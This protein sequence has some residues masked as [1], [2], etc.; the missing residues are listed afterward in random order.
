MA[1]YNPSVHPDGL[2]PD[3]FD[4]PVFTA[5][6]R[7]HQSLSRTGFR[8]VMAGLCL[9]SF[10]VSVWAWRMGFWP[11]AGFFGLDMLGIYLALKV[12]FRRGASFEEV[13]ISQIEILLAR[14]SHRGERR[15][16]RF[17]PLWTKIVS[18]DD[19]EF[20]L[21]RLTLVSRRQEVAVARDAGP[22]ERAR[23]ADGLSRA[24]ADIKKGR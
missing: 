14:V 1:S 8:V 4:R 17:N 24:L 15:E 6:I 2:D 23:I 20:G 19:D 22:E 9:V 13:M 18:V 7:P 3:S 10:A 16:W 12:S 11:I 5:T 21:Q